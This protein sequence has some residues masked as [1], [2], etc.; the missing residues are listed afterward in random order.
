[1]IANAH[2]DDSI[3]STM[4][5]QKSL[6]HGPPSQAIMPMRQRI[7]AQKEQIKKQMGGPIFDKVY[8]I[9]VMHKEHDTDP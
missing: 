6:S 3:G 9:L 5:T 8:K 7:E 1:M 4:M 2:L